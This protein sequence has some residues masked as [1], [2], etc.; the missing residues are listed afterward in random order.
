VAGLQADPDEPAV[1]GAARVGRRQPGAVDLHGEAVAGRV[2]V[3]LA[4]RVDELLGPYRRRV[5][6]LAVPDGALGVPV[7]GGVDVHG[8][9]RHGVL[10]RVDLTA[11]VL[12]CGARF[13]L[14]G[15]GGPA[16]LA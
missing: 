14:V 7:G 4:E 1:A 12:S 10:G 13:R 8:E 16:G 6:T 5:R 11:R 15:P 2:A 3:V 9:R